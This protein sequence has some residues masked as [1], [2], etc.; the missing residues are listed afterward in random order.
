MN[1]LERLIKEVPCHFSLEYSHIT[2]WH[3]YLWRKRCGKNGDDVV[4][5]DEW[6]VDLDYLISKCK[7]AYKD[8]LLE[9]EGG[10]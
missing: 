3:L 8:W 5:F 2:D 1:E 4:I 6:N 10:Y 9:N 7:V